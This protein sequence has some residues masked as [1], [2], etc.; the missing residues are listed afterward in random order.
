MKILTFDIEEWFH[1]LDHKATRTEREWSHYPP[2]IEENMD[3]ILHLLERKQQPATF[4]CLGWVAHK[5]PGIVRKVAD[6][7]YEI[8][9]HSHMHQ[10]IYEQTPEQFRADLR[11]ALH[12]IEDAT[13]KRVTSYRAPGFS[14]TRGC[15]WFFEILAEEGIEVDSSIFPAPR[16]HGGFPDFGASGP[17]LVQ[18]SSGIIKELPINTRSLFGRPVIFSGGGY[19]RILPLWLLRRWFGEADYVMTYFHPRD[20]DAAQPVIEELSPIRKFKSYVGLRG[21][22]AKLEAVLDDHDYLDLKTAVATIDW[23]RSPVIHTPAAKP[24]LIAPPTAAASCAT[25][26][27]HIAATN[28]GRQ[29]SR[30]PR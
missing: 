12:A 20:F 2:R 4:F 5:Y 7:G 25:G 18:T 23:E 15:P 26:E 16:A 27:S 17:A 19:F 30:P 3:R 24:P 29:S 22:L 11:D 8:G 21:A 6:R 9:C 28:H 1:I 14:V 10:L 13:G